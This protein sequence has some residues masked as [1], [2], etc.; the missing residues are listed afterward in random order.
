MIK[1][2]IF[3]FAIVTLTACASKDLSDVKEGMTSKEVLNIAGEPTEKVSM[4][5]DIEW[6]IYKEQKVLLILDSDTVSKV[7]SQKEIE[8]SVKDFQKGMKDIENEIEKLTK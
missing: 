2:L 5:L 4:P 1:K 6:W 7:T 8:E 3:I